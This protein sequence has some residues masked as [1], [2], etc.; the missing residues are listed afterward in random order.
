M[1]LTHAAHFQFINMRLGK[2]ILESNMKA[3]D[4]YRQLKKPR[5][6]PPA[7][8]F[9]PVWTVLYVIIAVSFGYVAY[10]YAIGAVS[11]LILLPFILNL[12]FNFAFTPI[13]F[14]LRNNVLAAVDI[15]LVLATLLWA[16]A[17]I[18]DE[19]AW[20]SLANVPY[21]VWVSFATVLQ[22]AITVMNRKP[23]RVPKEHTLR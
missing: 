22:L 8:L 10:Q 14:G 15:L 18:Y 13:Q 4:W 16:M 3:Y 20:V 11:F 7:W 5:F 21:L 9:S 23:P 2:C 19:A 6:A 17:S 1:F 12:V